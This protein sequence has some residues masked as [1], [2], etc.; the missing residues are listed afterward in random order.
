[1]NIYR[2]AFI[3]LCPAQETPIV[4][5]LELRSERMIRVEKIAAACRAWRRGFHE[6]VADGL[7][8]KFPRTLQ[9]LRAKHHGVEIETI[10]GVQ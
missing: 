7:A 6:D 3:V 10:R 5:A 2:H 8:A 4:Y 9:T 1:M